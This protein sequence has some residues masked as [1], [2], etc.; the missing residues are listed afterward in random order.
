MDRLQQTRF[1]AVAAVFILVA[2]GCAGMA[3]RTPVPAPAAR[4]TPVAPTQA[5]SSTPAVT[6]TSDL[7]YEA[8]NPWRD[9]PEVLDVY[10]P[11]APGSYPVVVMFHGSPPSN[12]KTS[13][14][15]QARSVAALGFVVFVP[16][17]GHL[18]ATWPDYPRLSYSGGQVA[19]AV[20]FA[21]LHA[22][23]FGGDVR[24]IVIFGHSGG[25]SAAVGIAFARPAPNEGCPGGD[26]L[27]AIDA[28]V[29]WDPDW[30]SMDPGWDAI[31][32]ADPRIYEAGT[33]WQ[34]IDRH[35]DLPVALVT[36]EIVGPY[37]RDLS[38]PGATDAFF[39]P[40]D[41]DGKLRALID[42]L[43]FLEDSRFDLVEME[44]FAAE[45][46][47]RQGNPVTLDVMPGTTHDA[48]SPDGMRVLLEVFRRR[49][50]AT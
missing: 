28:L 31:I 47:R 40:R 14:T 26:D 33:V 3:S 22:P 35:T 34:S 46:L 38:T 23:E 32:S 9:A 8:G 44:R 16:S 29:A 11:T 50:S 19:C 24:Q 15:T 10:A 49:L 5:T 43:G 18:G 1:A 45:F 13:L 21:R 6:V 12:S 4:P 36:D 27:G 17:W 48:M 20:A 2:V 25:G 37:V 41:H 42:E 39:A 7:P 30:L